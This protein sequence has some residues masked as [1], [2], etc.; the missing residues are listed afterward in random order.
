MASFPLKTAIPT[1]DVRKV[2][3]KQRDSGETMV[4]HASDLIWH[5]KIEALLSDSSEASMR[6]VF[7]AETH[8]STDPTRGW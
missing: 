2:A 4:F 3:S 8:C 6:E 7:I 5:I 1:L